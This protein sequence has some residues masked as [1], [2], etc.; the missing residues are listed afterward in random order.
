[1]E[2]KTTKQKPRIS[3]E[4]YAH[5][6]QTTPDGRATGWDKAADHARSDAAEFAR[7]ADKK[8]ASAAEFRRTG[9]AAAASEA[10]LEAAALRADER[11]CYTI[12]AGYQEEASREGTSAA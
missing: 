12:A 11:A 9:N 8:T 5:H 10:D 1:M 3:A 6:I 7:K 2:I 4:N